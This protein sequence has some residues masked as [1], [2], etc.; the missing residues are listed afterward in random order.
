[1]LG[2]ALG[3]LR[4]CVVWAAVGSAS[5]QVSAAQ[6]AETGELRIAGQLEVPRLVDLVADRLKV[7][8]EYDA[9]AIKGSSTL[10]IDGGVADGEL[11]QL[12]NRALAARGFTTVR[13]FPASPETLPSYSVVK[14]ADASSLAPIQMPDAPPLLGPEA[15]FISVVTRVQ[16]RSVREIV[17]AVG[18]SLSKPG[19]SVVP[20]GDSAAAKAAG[21]DGRDTS[22]DVQWV[23]IS[24]LSPRVHQAV[25]LLGMMDR[26]I[27][28][29]RKTVVR[30]IETRNLSATQIATLFAQ[31]AAKRKAVSGEDIPGDVL[32]AADEKHVLLV[33]PESRIPFWTE[34]VSSLDRREPVRTETYAPRFFPAEEVGKLIADSVQDHLDDRWRLVSDPLT[35]SILVTATPTQHAA[36]ESLLTRLNTSPPETR[37]PVRSFVVKNRSVAEIKG[38]LEQL[39]QAGVLA[40][41]SDAE[42]R[43]SDANTDA[44]SAATQPEI[45]NAPPPSAQSNGSGAGDRRHGSTRERSF[46]RGATSDGASAAPDQPLVMTSDE[47]TNTLIAVGEPRL[48]AQVETLLKSLDVRQPQVMLEVLM[49][50]LSEGQTFDLGVELEKLRLTDDLF[51]RL[52][53]LFGLS[54]RNGNGDRTPGDASGFTGVVLSPGDFSVVVRALQTVNDGRS[55]S[56]PKLL[57][58]NNQAATLDSTLQQPFASVNAGDTIATTSFGGTLDAG[59]VVSIKP[60]IAEGDHLLL[61]YSVSLSSFAGPAASATLPP[62]RAQNRVKSVATIPD[63][64]TVVVG[65]IDIETDNKS[66]SKVPL[67]GDIPLVGEAF[68]SRSKNSSR[69]RF[70]VFIRANVLRGRGS[71]GGAGGGFEDLKYIS[72]QDVARARVDDGWPEV[73]PRV[74]R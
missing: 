35:G 20:F 25:E 28:E 40:A 59:T 38:I 55:L 34:I 33:A 49:V 41:S 11:W 58:G 12:L 53:S 23:L 57:V 74:I 63:G 1:M 48:L 24:D 13:S 65:G 8:I 30:E 36:I 61:D 6:P 46:S 45:S 54:T 15:G 42:S 7:T 2:K 26:P 50:S 60:Q 5:L 39:L 17:E 31:V 52:S 56:M 67:L 69:S 62:P 47:G 72:D 64:Y 37:R 73:K 43:S 10:R 44:R 51:V 18:K 3:Q 71:G 14:V 66:E 70:F 22:S 21:G 4:G 68:K 9:A 16:H 32:A 29:G 19:G 27:E